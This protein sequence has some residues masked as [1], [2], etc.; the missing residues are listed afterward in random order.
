M[1]E[2][3]VSKTDSAINNL[4]PWRDNIPQ[5]VFASKIRFQIRLDDIRR[6]AVVD[7]SASL[8]DVLAFFNC[9]IDGILTQ[10]IIEIKATRGSTTWR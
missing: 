8:D 7:N 10:Y 5:K 2:E 4:E 1:Y 3:A 9:A 6:K